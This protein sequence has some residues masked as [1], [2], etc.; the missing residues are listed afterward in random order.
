[1]SS[2]MKGK[3]MYE[4]LTHL[5]TVN[6]VV[7]EVVAANDLHTVFTSVVLVFIYREGF[8]RRARWCGELKLALGRV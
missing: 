5:I 8:M 3:I 6:V 7:V 2:L 1:M 4:F